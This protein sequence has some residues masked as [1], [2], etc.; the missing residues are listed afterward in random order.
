MRFLRYIQP[1]GGNMKV[2]SVKQ[3]REIEAQIDASIISYE[4]LMLN[5]GQAAATYLMNR[6]RITDQTRITLLIGK[7]NNGGDGLVIAHHLAEHSSAEIRLYL[8]EPRQASDKNYQS[9]VDD[10]LLIVDAENDN[11]NRLL[12]SMINSA[13]IVIDALFG[14]GI[15]L[16]LRRQAV[17][18]LRTI[19]QLTQPTYATYADVNAIDPTQPN[20]L[21]ANPQPF[22]FAIDCPSGI[23]CD[24]GDADPNTLTAN[25][26]ITF[27]AA[28]HG[29]FAFPAAQHV[30]RLIISQISI[31]DTQSDLAQIPHFV[32]DSHFVRSHMPDRP[33]NGH[34]GTFGK[35]FI[36]A[37]SR[38]Y[39][40]ATA[41]AGESAYRSGAGIVTVATTTPNINIIASQLREPTF[42]HLPDIAGAISEHAVDDVVNNSRGYS[43]LLVGCGLAQNE[44]TKKFIQTLL[45]H[46]DLPSLILDAD[47]LNILS[48]RDQWWTLLPSDT[49]I[50]PHPG[51]MARLTGLTMD[52]VNANRWEI[53]AESAKKWDL[54]VVLKGAHTL[55]ASPEGQIGVIPFKTDA[56]GTAGTGDVLAGLIAGLRTQGTSAFDSAVVGTYIHAFAGMVAIEQ[57]GSSRSVIARDVLNALGRAFRRIEGN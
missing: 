18:I 20:Q 47:A 37:G 11:D 7:G 55:I 33:I 40:G 10:K 19:N 53:A 38:N 42:V 43:A 1:T 26:T 30:G 52:E 49:I 28:K 12:K 57:V 27:I 21:P 22:I 16:P 13:D 44:T 6:L 32:A 9:V 23:D 48:Q 34:K 56:L 15:R 4:Q 8:L 2:V 41:L 54:I 35:T 50:T 39:I 17:T 24:T 46:K 31:P 51:E 36:V 45:T 3:I 25:E 5:A 14:I 29:H